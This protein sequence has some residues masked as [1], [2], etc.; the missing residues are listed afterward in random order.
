MC[1]GRSSYQTE[2]LS[3]QR[4]YIFLH[5]QTV[6]LGSAWTGLRYVWKAEPYAKSAV[7]PSPWSPA[8][9]TGTRGQ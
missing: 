4:F 9:G 1:M 3:E 8:R 7:G 2:H 5:V 6:T